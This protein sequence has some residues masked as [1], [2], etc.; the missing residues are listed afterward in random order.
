MVWF[1]GSTADDFY[2]VHGWAARGRQGDKINHA[3]GLSQDFTPFAQ[4][5]IFAT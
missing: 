1:P 4:R 5:V 3:S 2:E